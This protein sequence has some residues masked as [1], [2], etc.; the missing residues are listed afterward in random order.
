MV[1]TYK[2]SK[3]GILE[4]PMLRWGLLRRFLLNLSE[5]KVLSL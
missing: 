3:I 2:Q 1:D 4:N 5:V